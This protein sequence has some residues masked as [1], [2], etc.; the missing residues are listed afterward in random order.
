MTG[1][2][3]PE[4][5]LLKNLKVLDLAGN[6]L[7]G[8][9]PESLYDIKEMKEL[10]LYHNHLTGT[11]SNQIKNW[12]NI[13]RLHLSH[14]KLSGSIPSTFMSGTLTRPVEYL[15]LYSNQLTG[16]I[17]ELRLRNLV[18]ADFGRNYLTGR[19]PNDIG[20]TWASLRH[21]YLDYNK[22]TGSIPYSITTTGNGRVE[23]LSFNN[24]QLTGWVPGYYQHYKL[25][26][27]HL[28]SNSFTGIDHATCKQA[29]FHSG[30][31]VEFTAECDICYCTPF[32][33]K[34]MD[35]RWH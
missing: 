5:N 31:M 25:L 11:I 7:H 10:Y 33:R 8:S 24:N 35:E 29:V 12:W 2:I 4:I 6:K 21:L 1:T 17:P 19:L 3:P 18:Y 32:C 23:T 20:Y 13:T 30:E 9:I 34:C 26:E 22:F 14:N 27:L 16:T 28:H 15:N